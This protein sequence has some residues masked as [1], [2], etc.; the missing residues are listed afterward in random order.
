MPDYLAMANLLGIQRMVVVQ[1]SVSGTDNAVTLDAVAQFG[2]HRARAVAVID[3]GCSD[4][5]LRGMHDRGVRGVRFNIA[6]GGARPWISWRGWLDGWLRWVG[7]SRSTPKG[8]RWRRWDRGWRSC[9]WR[10]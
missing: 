7:T 6:T 8:K 9:R 3:D 10:W 1:A 4:A 5:V 2:L